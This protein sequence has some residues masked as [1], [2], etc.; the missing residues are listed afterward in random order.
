[1]LLRV[2]KVKISPRN[3][4]TKFGLKNQ[5]DR[6]TYLSIRNLIQIS[7][8]FISFISTKNNVM[9]KTFAFGVRKNEYKH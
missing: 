4:K 1:M 8:Y 3:L 9:K 7:F 2:N 6:V 5:Y